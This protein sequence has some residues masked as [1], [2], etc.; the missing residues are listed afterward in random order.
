MANN[1]LVM[2]VVYEDN[3]PRTY[4]GIEARL[5][6][7]KIGVF[8]SGN[9]RNDYLNAIS[10]TILPLAFSPSFDRFIQDGGSFAADSELLTDKEIVSLFDGKGRIM[11][12][13][14]HDPKEEAEYNKVR[15][16]A[17]C[18]ADRVGLV[19][20]R[21][22]LDLREQMDIEEALEISA[23]INLIEYLDGTVG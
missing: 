8:D 4:S 14:N 11:H 15:L 18:N 17:L 2:D 9:P 21:R 1:V 3:D 19:K 7:T 20:G 5:E 12:N 22:D 13:G 10:F 16:N 6:N 23:Q